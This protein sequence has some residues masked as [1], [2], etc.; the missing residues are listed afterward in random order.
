MRAVKENREYTI[1]EV[2]VESFAKEGYD[3]Y[4]ESG[5]IVRYGAGKTVSYDKYMKLTSSMRHSWKRTP[6]LL[7]RPPSSKRKNP[8][9]KK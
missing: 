6:S 3:I 5:N 1:T 9:R 7:K 8:R 4:D 2:D